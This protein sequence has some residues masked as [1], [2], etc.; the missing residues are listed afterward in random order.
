[1]LTQNVEKQKKKKTGEEL[2]HFWIPREIRLKGITFFEA[3]EEGR[4]RG[5]Y[6]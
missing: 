3:V 4:G 5:P 6:P 2:L 1:M